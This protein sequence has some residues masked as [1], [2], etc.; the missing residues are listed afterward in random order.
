M[1]LN[2][3]HILAA[4]RTLSFAPGKLRRFCS[5]SSGFKVETVKPQRFGIPILIAKR[6]VLAAALALLALAFQSSGMCC[7]LER[8]RLAGLPNGRH[9]LT[10]SWAS[11][12]R[13][14][15]RTMHTWLQPQ[16]EH[17]LLPEVMPRRCRPSSRIRPHHEAPVS[18]RSALHLWYKI[19][20]SEAKAMQRAHGQLEAERRCWAALQGRR[21]RAS[22]C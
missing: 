12:D 10:V 6:Q 17:T 14:E 8:L 5:G 21:A 20:V 13:A 4:H 18:T 2:S 19:R 22:L 7:G 15:M 1:P 3:R 9:V 16:R 11:C